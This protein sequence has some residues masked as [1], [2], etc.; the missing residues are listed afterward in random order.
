MR[1]TLKA[2]L[3]VLGLLVL[4]PLALLS[5]Y[6]IYRHV[7][8]VQAT[9]MEQLERRLATTAA[10]VNERVSRIEGY[11]YALALSDSARH[12]DL[13]ALHAQAR[14]LVDRD[15]SL[16]SI[17]L[18]NPD[19][20]LEFN[21]QLP[22]DHRKVATP[23]PEEARRVFETGQP[24]LSGPFQ[25]AYRD[26]LIVT[27]GVPLYQDGRIAYVL[28]AVLSCASLS[29]FLVAQAFPPG[30]LAGILDAE[31]VVIARSQAADQFV[32]HSSV[33]ELVAEVKNPRQV[34][35]EAVSQEGI[36]T[37]GMIRR[38]PGRDWSVAVGAPADLLFAPLRRQLPW[39]VFGWAAAL[40]IGFAL[41]MTWARRMERFL[42]G[43]LD[44]I[45]AIAAG[46]PWEPPKAGMPVRELDRFQ[47][48]LM[49]LQQHQYRTR[50]EALAS[51]AALAERTWELT[52]ANEHLVSLHEQ[53]SG[54]QQTAAAEVV[55][56]RQLEEALRRSETNLLTILDHT[57]VAIYAS[58]GQEQTAH[59][60][61]KAFMDFFGY[62]PEEVQ[63]VE[64][65]WPR[66][67]PDPAYRQQVREEWQAR[68]TQAIATQSAIQPMD[69]RVCSKDGRYRIIRWGYVVTPTENWA[70]GLDLTEHKEAE[71][72]LRRRTAQLQETQALAQI[73]RWSW[74]L[75]SQIPV[76]DEGLFQL[77]RRDPGAAPTDIQD[78]RRYFTPASWERIV[79]EVEQSLAG[80]TSFE[81]DAELLREDGTSGWVLIRG[82][83]RR[84]TQGQVTGVEGLMQDITGRKQAEH[85]LRDSER[86]FRELFEHLPIAYQS[87][88]G[89]GR[90]LDANQKMA[91][92][93]GFAKPGDLLGLSF[94]DY[95]DISLRDRFDANFE[96]F[97]ANL[98]LNGEVTLCRRDGM[99]LTVLFAG[100]V[101]R[102]DQ[103]R[104]LRTHC[105]LVDISERQAM[106]EAIRDLNANLE[107]KVADR[108]QELVAAQA[109]LR[110][111]LERV[112]RSEARFRTMFEQAPLGIA[113]IDSLTG[114]IQEVNDRFAAIAGRSRA[115]MTRIDWMPLTHAD[116]AQDELDQMARLDAG[117]IAS[118]QMD[119]QYLHP[120]GTAVWIRITIAPVTAER[121]E[122]PRHL[123]LIE[124][125]SERRRLEEALAA[126]EERFRLAMEAS[127]DGLW[128]WRMDSDQAYCNPAY[129]QMLG[130]QSGEL[131]PDPDSLWLDLLHPD[132]RESTVAR[133]GQALSGAGPF[134]AEYRL[135]AKDGGYRWILGRGRT[136]QRD[137]AGRPLRALGTHVDITERRRYE[138][139]LAE[140]KDQ[141]EAANRAKSSFL[142]T[143]SHEIRTPMN[144]ILGMAQLL[145]GRQVS[146]QERLDHAQMILHA[147]ETLLTLLNDILDLSKVEAG[148][149]TL[150]YTDF[151]PS[152]LLQQVTRLFLPVVQIKE[153]G[154]CSTWSGPPAQRYRGDPHRLRQMLSNLVNN[155]IKFSSDGEIRVE[156]RELSRAGEAALLEFSVADSGVGVPQDKQ[157]SLFRPFA[158]AS[159]AMTQRFG[160]TGLG[161]SIVR[162]LAELMG[163]EVGLE[164]RVN[165]GSR[166]WF[167]VR[168]EPVGAGEDQRQPEWNA[169]AA[170]SEEFARL[171]GRV[172]AVDDSASNREVIRTMLTKLDLSVI[173]AEDGQQ[174]L[175]I[176]R[177][178]E[179]VDLV[180]MDLHMPAMDGY[181]AVQQIRRWEQAHQRPRLPIIALT[182]DVFDD[183]RQRA[184][185]VGMDGVLAKPVVWAALRELLAHWLPER[186]AQQRREPVAAPRTLDVA[187][188]EALLRESLPLL[189]QQRF[190][191]VARFR[192]L[193]TLVRGTEVEAEL[194][195]AGA[196]VANMDFSRA[197][198]LL[199]ELAQR[200]GWKLAAS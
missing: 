41:V 93:L 169:E 96:R 3:A 112:A 137:A 163:G 65:W 12:G 160:G 26:L 89:Q 39:L 166:F 128:D 132:D 161:L 186:T 56:R 115:E 178:G 118:F 35:F 179:P 175:D 187:R 156:G 66:A 168:L 32:G 130:Y 125:I 184:L 158:Q 189:E 150:E 121:G 85:N 76:W 195:L 21:S 69:V 29:E 50:Q 87:I 45:R 16:V 98:G 83:A 57:P 154:L 164:S 111:L 54:L 167:R 100:R 135:R 88:D 193:Q 33:P 182:A 196:A 61:N 13:A 152:Q 84:D 78:G 75:D 157:A 19:Y 49:V 192:D 134:E 34:V 31:G 198:T 7:A 133:V 73:G 82:R 81:C 5:G 30:W 114:R 22:L 2:S 143:M 44:G 9:V 59:Y 72:A 145:L 42:G 10:A 28:R 53:Q 46:N 15:P 181:G 162:S 183:S 185:D 37:Q 70:F 99:P 101:Q 176:I 136:V 172:L 127:Q 119:K 159:G 92:L 71:E 142:A 116:G 146:K 95:W 191:A 104:F 6:S 18:V 97:K 67:Y 106:E 107:R 8:D 113:L 11:L 124:D 129:F 24:V 126:S 170:D 20:D 180:L 91:D 174:G 40:G 4:L 51:A 102:D 165:D 90:W 74:D 86:R 1:M 153:L 48:E 173:E 64:D 171:V 77:F 188:V 138:A 144:A 177:R 108:T 199:I 80:G 110:E 62:G 109:E 25:S 60:I 14:A 200:R 36:A 68:V 79:A 17:V 27:L 23:R 194:A 117:E 105:I 52:E 43:T 131:G 148:R 63:R 141:A 122:S 149:M 47:S 94:A 140:A 120:D 190:N 103:G 38:L 151:D 123:V 139:E 147:G 58:S 55:A 155:A 197:R